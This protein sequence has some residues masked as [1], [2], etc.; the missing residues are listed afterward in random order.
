MEDL[1]RELLQRADGDVKLAQY[2]IIASMKSINRLSA[3][4]SSDAMSAGAACVTNLLKLMEETE[5]ALRSPNDLP[6]QLQ[7][8]MEFSARA[9]S[10]GRRSIPSTFFHCFRRV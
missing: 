5:V 9:S 1:V 2:G 6:S 8:A 3:Q 7:A 10:N 4:S